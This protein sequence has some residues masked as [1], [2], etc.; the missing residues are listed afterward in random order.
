[1]SII[2]NKLFKNTAIVLAVF[3]FFAFVVPQA[4]F[5]IP[6]V[7]FESPTKNID[8]EF[9][10]TDFPTGVFRVEAVFSDTTAGISDVVSANVFSSP[11]TLTLQEGEWKI[12]AYELAFPGFAVVSESTEKTIIVNPVLETL[13][14]VE[15]HDDTGT[16]LTTDATSGV[17]IKPGYDVYVT[18]RA[19]GPKNETAAES[20]VNA[21]DTIASIFFY[22]KNQL[23]FESYQRADGTSNA[24]DTILPKNT[25]GAGDAFQN[26]RGITT[27]DHYLYELPLDASNNAVENDAYFDH[28]ETVPTK[29]D[30]LFYGNAYVSGSSNSN[31]CGDIYP[32][33]DAANFPKLTEA[34]NSN[35]SDL[36]D[37]D[38][39]GYQA[40]RGAF[41]ANAATAFPGTG[42]A[43]IGDDASVLG[44]IKFSVPSSATH[45]NFDIITTASYTSGDTIVTPTSYTENIFTF[46]VDTTEPT[47]TETALLSSNAKETGAFN[48]KVTFD[49]TVENVDI[50][51]F[52]F[53]ETDS[54]S[55]T[56]V[57]T[58]AGAI[59][60]VE[61]F[62]SSDV[63]QG[64]TTTA[65]TVSGD[66][67]VVSVIPSDQKKT[68]TNITYSFEVVVD[69]STGIV[70]EVGNPIDLA[71][72]GTDYTLDVV[73]DTTFSFS[74]LS[75][76]SAL[77]TLNGKERTNSTTIAVQF[78]AIP[79]PSASNLSILVKEGS[80]VT[81]N[82]SN[83]SITDAPVNSS[84]NTYTANVIVSNNTDSDI[85]YDCTLT[86]VDG[87]NN[88]SLDLGAFVVDTVFDTFALKVGLS[89]SDAFAASIGDGYINI[90]EVTAGAIANTSLINGLSTFIQTLE[91]S[92]VVSTD[93]T[94]LEGNIKY[95]FALS[96]ASQP[97]TFNQ[98]APTFSDL[99]GGAVH[100]G[101]YVVWV[102]A[103]DELGNTTEEKL[104]TDGT[105]I[106]FE[107]DTIAPAAPTVATT[108][109]VAGNTTDGSRYLN[110]ATVT[111]ASQD[112]ITAT[113]GTNVITYAKTDQS[114]DCHTLASYATDTIKTDNSSFQADGSYRICAKATD[115]AGNNSYLT[116][117]FKVDVTSP[118]VGINTTERDSL[119]VYSA[120]VYYLNKKANEGT[121]TTVATPNQNETLYNVEYAL[122]AQTAACDNALTY[123][124]TAIQTN[125][126]AFTDGTTHRVCASVEDVAGNVEY[127]DLID[128]T[129]EYTTPV[130]SITKIVGTPD[131]QFFLNTVESNITFTA[132][133]TSTDEP[134]NTTNSCES[135]SSLTFPTSVTA[136]T[137][138][139]LSNTG[140][141]TN[142]KL[143]CFKAVNEFGN[144]AI[145]SSNQ[146]SDALS[147]F[148]AIDPT[149]NQVPDGS[150]VNE[151]LYTN[152]TTLRFTG[153]AT[154]STEIK[155]YFTTSATAPTTTTTTANDTQTADS[156]TGIV[157]FA[158]QL[159]AENSNH[160]IWATAQADG[161]SVVTSPFMVLRM[162]VDTDAPTVTVNDVSTD[163]YINA[164]E[165]AASL[166]ISGTTTAEDNQTVTVDFGGVTK[167]ST[168]SSGAWSVSLTSAEQSSISDGVVIADVSVSDRASNEVVETKNVT[169][170]T[171]P[172]TLTIIEIESGRYLA[173]S[174]S[175]TTDT[176][177]A[178]TSVSLGGADVNCSA[179][180]INYTNVGAEVTGQSTNQVCFRVEDAVGNL[181]Y[182]TTNNALEGLANTT[183]GT[184][185]AGTVQSRKAYT[186][187]TS[188]SFTATTV[189]DVPARIELRA[190]DGVTVVQTS[191]VTADSSGN[192][193]FDF[194]N[195]LVGDYQLYGGIQPAG[196]T[197]YTQLVLILEL[198]I[199]AT[200][201]TVDINDIST[202]NYV[203]TTEKASSLTI[204]GTTTAEDGQTVTVD[205]GGLVTKTA[206]V[207]SG[208]WSVSITSSEQSSIVDGA[209]TV[210]ASTTDLAS[211]DGSQ[212]VTLTYDTTAPSLIIVNTETGSYIG[213]GDATTVETRYKT[214]STALGSAAVNCS[215]LTYTD[216][217]SSITGQSTNQVCFRVEDAFGNLAYG[218]TKNAIEGLG[219]TSVATGTSGTVSGGKT[220]TNNI[221]PSF[222]STTAPNTPAR[223]ELRD[224]GGTVVTSTDVT[225]DSSGNVTFSLGNISAG[226]YSLYGGIQP[227]GATDY[228]QLV[229]ILALV[230]DTTAPTANIDAISSDNV[231]NASE[232]SSS[233]T[234]SGDSNA[235]TGQNV[236]IDFG[237][238]FSLTA[239]VS[240]SG[241]YTVTATSGQ[242][243]SIADGH[244]RNHSNCI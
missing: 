85:E 102:Q 220:Y 21:A 98:A 162:Y 235:E 99:L 120:P 142:A 24:L 134:D 56:D 161:S 106:T 229:P 100:D 6:T 12:T 213:A 101:T 11:V 14:E 109:L 133:V 204:S 81:D 62:D 73:I 4:A 223:I 131:N 32:K 64:S 17:K 238:E 18:Y 192:V 200:L 29:V 37:F 157:S 144:E 16:V 221:S 194:G 210:S 209:I 69:T 113:G 188:P 94:T 67:F 78:D 165:K 61:A 183:L 178:T 72:S 237:G 227:A 65:A 83:L 242:I 91:D 193:T 30:F 171:T 128:F 118:T 185:V 167:T 205:L 148:T 51:D 44:K 146:S 22:D 58:S 42:A 219:G 181:A 126:P 41:G 89:L 240:A 216:V 87:T 108:V 140:T 166:T 110:E 208:A 234:I 8:V 187:T 215:S 156:V 211:N 76:T 25:G 93:T 48:V 115:P 150:T 214:T 244:L 38:C 31:L 96:T 138:T 217:G 226:E 139:S 43:F 129:A 170:D 173:A 82:C 79:A 231:V 10:V 117:N 63:S 104:N 9:E 199:D 158:G 97:T 207:T 228:T 107:L 180:S 3:A 105:D 201:P 111:G 57:I 191:D 33:L 20:L 143:V 50:N 49:E 45:G 147:N 232:K 224:A 47:V 203:N 152:V 230:I 121:A 114:T 23:A 149:T 160:Y 136:H 60:N 179:S 233:V 182:D 155:L 135:N 66:Y 137:T 190:T 198:S 151:I 195:L 132:Q 112:V 168:V 75:V 35:S 53:I 164:V 54:T 141:G 236:S 46:T 84:G 86:Y 5:A 116:Q 55:G 77:A 52:Q 119:F 34:G 145:L 59:S 239:S 163:N 88:V 206:T 27:Y 80:S 172:P 184:G 212:S 1:M 202:D 124:A 28:S 153:T 241:T 71:N 174:D 40:Q 36:A 15:I 92:T 196:A 177:Y 103:A 243:S 90:A 225:S 130:F 26:T 19:D 68:D 197:D 218:T 159:F 169:Y 39:V 154:P 125:N 2:V 175:T 7:T 13:V 95:A 127:G 176:R 123:G 222:T 74:D 189:A 70:D 186:N 122:V